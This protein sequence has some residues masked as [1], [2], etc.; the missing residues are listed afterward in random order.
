MAA[1]RVKVEGLEPLLKQVAALGKAGSRKVVRDG[2]R[3]AIGPMLAAA[4]SAAP[5][6]TGLL[7]GSI[8]AKAFRQEGGKFAVGVQTFTTR[9]I[10]FKK[11]FGLKLSGKPSAGKYIVFYA[12]FLEFGFRRGSRRGE[13]MRQLQSA[14]RGVARAD[15]R[16]QVPAIHGGKGFLRPAWDA[17][18]NLMIGDLVMSINQAIDESIKG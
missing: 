3:R 13:R 18:E 12:R 6:A 5:V 11:R 17:R 8:K 9:R 4:K 15:K 10:A 16:E 2:L 7:R 14:V 1:V